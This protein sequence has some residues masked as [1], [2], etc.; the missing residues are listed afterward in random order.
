MNKIETEKH[1]LL[2]C[3]QYD[4]IRSFTSIRLG[5][6]FSNLSDILSFLESALLALI[7]IF[8]GF[9]YSP[10][11]SIESSKSRTWVFIKL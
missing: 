5:Q 10:F 8:G 9:V 4:G 2:E 11:G 3:S 7:E 1:F 6:W